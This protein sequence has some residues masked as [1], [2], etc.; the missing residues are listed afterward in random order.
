MHSITNDDLGRRL[1]FGNPWWDTNNKTETIFPDLPERAFYTGFFSRLHS[2]EPGRVLVM[3]GPPCVGKTT[4]LH[5]ATADLLARGV[6][7][8]EILYCDL[9]APSYGVTPPARLVEAAAARF[10]HGPDSVLYLFFDEAQYLAGW[11]EKLQALASAW[12]NA[13]IVAAVSCDAG[14]AGSDWETFVL[15]PLTFAEFLNYRKDEERLLGGGVSGAG[16]LTS[17]AMTM[18]PA[19]IP[20]FNDAFAEYVNFGGFPKGVVAGGAAGS[21]MDF[22]RDGVAGRVLHRDL[23]GRHGIGDPGDLERLFVVLA[24]NTASEVTIEEL[25][26]VVGVAKNTLRKYLDFLEQAFLIRRL[27]RLDREGKRFQRA[28]AFKVYLTAPCLYAALFGPV[29]RDD[30]MFSR[31]AET[32][33]VSQWLGSA[34]GG[35]L[36][37]ASWR[38]GAIDL[39]EMNPE[40]DKPDN[41]YEFD[42]HDGYA[43]PGPKADK[44]PA[45]LTSFVARTNGSAKT[46]ILTA[47][48]ARRGAMAG[49]EIT[50]A[51]LALYAYRIG[52]DSKGGGSGTPNGGG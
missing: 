33:L 3:A 24:R 26:G 51:P 34:D 47:S 46:H 1:S 38:G 15:P 9:A 2:Q 8:E 41:V 19:A 12:P 11:R 25:T 17:G 6:A 16:G 4:M 42:W 37:Y 32:A 22:I 14:P 23:A 29:T 35:R 43:T 52:R 18:S 31:L 28:I 10:G 27:P 5:Q 21:G 36:A 48:T 40:T 7:G 20:A 30:R 39:L 13:R 49:I 45:E 44:G 50:L